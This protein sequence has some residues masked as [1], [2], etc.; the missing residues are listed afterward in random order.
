M[1]GAFGYRK[2]SYDLSQKIAGLDPLLKSRLLWQW[3]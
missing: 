2:E 1:A 3:H